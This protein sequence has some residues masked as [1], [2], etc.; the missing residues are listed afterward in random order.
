MDLKQ[1]RA[2]MALYAVDVFI[3]GHKAKLPKTSSSGARARLSRG[4]D[5][6]ALYI[7][8]QEAGALVT[9]QLTQAKKAKRTA[10]VRDFMT[11]IARIAKLESSRVPELQPLKTPRGEPGVERLLGHAAGMLVVVSQHVE[12]FVELGLPPTVVEDMLAAIDA[13]IG[14]ITD[15]RNQIGQRAGATK[16]V[17]RMIVALNKQKAVLDSFV[18]SDLKDSPSLFASWKLIKRAEPL[19]GRRRKASA[20]EA[21]P[22][23]QLGAATMPV[24]NPRRLLA[25]PM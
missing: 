4:L 14:T 20:L 5:E 17:G 16:G 1:G 19:P 10:L 6:L 22:N 3:D 12:L 23:K 11:P 7:R 8:T 9:K 25:S 2:L 24:S 13:V 21:P 15:R 18:R